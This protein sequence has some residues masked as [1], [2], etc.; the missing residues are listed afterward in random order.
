MIVS[1]IENLEKDVAVM[2]NYI[3]IENMYNNYTLNGYLESLSIKL[4]KI[5]YG[6]DLYNLNN[7]TKNIAGIDLVDNINGVAVQ[8]TSNAD[9]KKINKTIEIFED[10]YINEYKQLY[11]FGFCYADK[12]YKVL[13]ENVHVVNMNDFILKL[14]D[15]HDENKIQEVINNIREYADYARL[16]PYDDISCLKILLEIVDR[17]AIKHMMSCEGDYNA[18]ISGLNEI[19]ELI[20]KGTINGQYKGKD[21][22]Q[23][24]NQNI[25]DYMIKI[26][27]DIS[28][29]LRIINMNK[30]NHHSDIIYLDMNEKNGIDNLKRDII[31]NSNLIARQFNI[32]YNI[33][34]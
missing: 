8:V 17:S 2:Q 10:R 11:I 12:K 27:D 15:I 30:N 18:M 5:A 22:E 29:I 31:S 16:H 3:N 20:S 34:E 13:K 14:R 24:T 25:K 33:I 19:T 9:K 21:I 7:D 4:F 6:F 26:R 28:K 1:L 23:F 32:M